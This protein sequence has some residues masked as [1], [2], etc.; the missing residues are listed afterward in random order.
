MDFDV[1]VL[2]AGI[3]GVSSALHLQDRGRRVG[4]V[5]R[6]GPGEE[7]SFGNAGLI[8]SS[9]VV[10]YGFPR[11]LGTLLRY[12]RNRSTDLYWDYKALPSFAT[13]LARFW[14][15]SSPERLEA[16]AHDMLPLIRRSVAEHDV[17]IARAGLQ[18][19]AHDGGW[20]EAFRTR[21][22]YERQAS[23]AEVTARTYGLRVVPCDAD[24]LM[25]REPGIASGFSGALH[26]QDPKSISNPGALTKGYAR[27]FDEGGGALLTGEV[28]TV[29]QEADA[30]TVQTSQGRISAKEVVVALG[31]WSDKVF[32]PL[33]YRIPLRA[34]RGYHMHYEATKSMLSI[35]LVDTEKGYVVAPM[36]GRLRLTTGVE[37]ARRDAPPTSVQLDRA[38]AL[39][40]P[41]FGLGR[42][43]DDAPW[44]GL[45][46]C[47][48]DMRPVIGRA[49]RHR[50]LWFSFGH[51]HH[52]L[53]LGPVT[54]RLL[55]EMM[56]GGEPIT[57]P[58]P[59]RPER[60]R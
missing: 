59:F 11:D 2:G 58:H 5:D 39:A 29:R 42:R 23:A 21:S 24:A 3:V 48:P 52:G 33:G 55:A 7:T 20:I 43:L 46:P 40:R 1:I 22:E 60:F 54:G 45:R 16:A 34:K 8:E 36:Q 44:L 19:L 4:L 28:V 6:R 30:W 27:L 25:A 15:E 37:I 53:T 26:W 49:P 14:W 13:W 10:P 17:L 50:G 38:E 51:N 18:S 9:S 56:T 31:P 35:P 57:D 41:I 47:T 32:E 12:L